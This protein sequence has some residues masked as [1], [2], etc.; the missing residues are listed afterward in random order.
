M[1][2]AEAAKN[3]ATLIEGT[4]TK[5]NDGSSLVSK[6]A[7]AFSQVAVSTGKVKELVAEIAAASGEQAQGVEQI[8]KAVTEMNTVT[9]QTAAN[10]EESASAS[11]ELSAQSETMKG[12]VLQ[13]V[14]M[15]GGEANGNGHYAVHH[16]VKVGLAR[17]PRGQGTG[18]GQKTLMRPT[19]EQF[20]PF[21]EEQCKDF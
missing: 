9:Q 19:L 18:N 5:V 3:T 7:E 12:A 14:D 8:N 15:V 4:V 10:A 1:R 16:T 11:E 6:T 2:A 20:M 17:Q 13:L 21:E